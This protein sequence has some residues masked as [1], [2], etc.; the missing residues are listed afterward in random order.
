VADRGAD[1]ANPPEN[2]FQRV[3]LV[4]WNSALYALPLFVELDQSWLGCFGGQK[5]MQEQFFE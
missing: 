2:I 4:E 3:G 1:P 5:V